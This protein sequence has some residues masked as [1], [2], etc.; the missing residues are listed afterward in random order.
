MHKNSALLKRCLCKNNWTRMLFL[1]SYF[2]NG[3]NLSEI[4]WKRI[5]K[6]YQKKGN[7]IYKMLTLDTSSLRTWIWWE[8][9]KWEKNNWT[10]IPLGQQWDF[11]YSNMPTFGPVS[12]YTSKKKIYFAKNYIPG[13][14]HLELKKSKHHSLQWINKWGEKVF[15]SIR[16]WEN[17]QKPSCSWIILGAFLLGS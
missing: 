2:S 14:E 5:K 4:K 15:G 12:I 16:E 17:H 6:N 11:F 1:F 9:G 10:T 3:L 8:M 13:L 7:K